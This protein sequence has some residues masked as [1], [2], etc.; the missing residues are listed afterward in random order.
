MENNVMRCFLNATVWQDECQDS[1]L[2]SC[3]GKSACSS[4]CG[5]FSDHNHA[6]DLLQHPDLVCQAG[7]D[8]SQV[9]QRRNDELNLMRKQ[10]AQ[11]LGS[12]MKADEGERMIR[13]FDSILDNGSF[14]FTP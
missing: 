10:Y 7:N 9:T 3:S 14:S 12:C 4:P 5:V 13:C 2:P 6:E 8:Q 1:N 11:E